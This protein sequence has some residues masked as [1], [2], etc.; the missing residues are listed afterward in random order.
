M[1][2]I[3]PTDEIDLSS[4]SAL[5]SEYGPHTKYSFIP[6]TTCYYCAPHCITIHPCK[7][8]GLLK[9]TFA[10]S[11]ACFSSRPYRVIRM[12]LFYVSC[13]ICA[14]KFHP[15]I[16]SNLQ[17]LIKDIH[18]H[19]P[20]SL[21]TFNLLFHLLLPFRIPSFCCYFEASEAWIFVEEKDSMNL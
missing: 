4:S 12:V 2:R 15:I 1:C 7:I 5:T 9:A 19:T 14:D 16:R 21:S 18:H 10:I 13:C 8:P 6:L 3:Q 20:V 17:L 11:A